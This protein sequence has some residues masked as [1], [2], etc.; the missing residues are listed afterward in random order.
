MPVDTRVALV[1]CAI[2]PDL[3]DDDHLL[4]DALR[5]RGVAVDAVRW[6]D[7]DADWSVYDL[8]VIRS[9]WDYVARCDQFV[10]WARGVPRLANPADIIAWNTDKRYLSELAE[11]GVPVIPTGFVGPG[12]TWSPPAEGEWVVKP[13]VSAGSQDTARYTLPAQL[14][15]ARA[16]VTRLTTTGRTAMIQPY[17]SAIETAGETAVLCLPDATGELT[18]SHAIR[19]GPMLRHTGEHQIDPGTEDIAPRTPSEA[20][21]EVARLALAAVPGGAKRLLY[22]RVDVIPGPDGAPMM[23][24]FELTEPSLFFSTAPGAAERLADAILA[25]V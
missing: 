17:L 22:A 25:R 19:K 7:T 8:T 18:F 13:T 3:W 5:A 2:F 23:V 16:H 11:A 15:A 20:E 6:D 14:E 9:P 21:L 1:T 4:R 12:E 10:D 24:E